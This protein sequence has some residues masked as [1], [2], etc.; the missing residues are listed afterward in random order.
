M[1]QNSDLG[2]RLS[3]QQIISLPNPYTN[4]SMLP[5]LSAVPQ[6][7]NMDMTM[8]EGMIRLKRPT[9]ADVYGHLPK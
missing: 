4:G 7:M 5:K 1:K 8:L 6:K 2:K 9:H 3:D